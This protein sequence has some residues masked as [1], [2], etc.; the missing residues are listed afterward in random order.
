MSGNIGRSDDGGGCSG[1]MKDR[2]SAFGSKV[3]EDVSS[4]SKDEGTVEGT[5]SCNSRFEVTSEF[6][7]SALN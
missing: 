1:L 3:E 6:Q 7:T 5:L 4:K 2:M